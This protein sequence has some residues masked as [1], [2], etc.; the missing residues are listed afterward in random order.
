MAVDAGIL[1][2]VTQQFIAALRRDA[3]IIQSAAKS[4]FY[5]LVLIQLVLS[6]LWM[7][8]AGESLQRFVVKLVQLAFSFGFFY[9][10]IQFGGEWIPNLIN[11]F[12]ELGQK[13]GV[14][15][16][17]PSS[18][19]SQ[20]MSISSAIF[21]G[22]FNWGLL[23]HPFVSLVGA[24][25]C[26]AVLILYGLMA[27]ELTIVLVKS[28][29]VIA[30]G[31]LF[32]AFGGSDVT[33]SMAKNYFQSAIGLGLQL[34][35]LYMLLGVGQH[36][37]STWAQMTAEAANHHALMPMLV[38][39]CAVIVYYMI[40]KNIPPF[41][42]GFS[43][44]GGFRNYGD[45][46]VGMAINTGMSGARLLSRTA[47]MTGGAA[48]GLGQLGVAGKHVINSAAPFQAKHPIQGSGN[49]LSGFSRVRAGIQSATRNI[50]GAAGNT[51]KDMVMK[52]SPNMSFGQKFNRHIANKINSNKKGE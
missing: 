15:S 26:I 52:K 25:V 36:I 4:L 1:D 13:T 40:L 22:F 12:I 50:A 49:Q 51:V 18:I 10:L 44:V 43:G 3:V 14:Q 32:F 30:L 24:I 35:T 8:F 5:Y 11:G 16:L 21:K 34:M 31:G 33:R 37:G 6:A 41:I 9:S 20:G 28:Y 27:A 29:I 46:A 19:V 7:S 45:A 42:A 47:G 38:I 23:S 48:Q 2:Q 39:L 17:D